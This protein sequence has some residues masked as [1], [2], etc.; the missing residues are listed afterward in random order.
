LYGRYTNV[1]H[2]GE[3]MTEYRFADLGDS[4]CQGGSAIDLSAAD[5]LWAEP[6]PVVEDNLH[7]PV[8]V[9]GRGYAWQNLSQARAVQLACAAAI[10]AENDPGGFAYVLAGHG[11]PVHDM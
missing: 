7:R 8:A 5:P 2:P 10:S 6:L 9:P 3:W 4:R 11:S 1:E